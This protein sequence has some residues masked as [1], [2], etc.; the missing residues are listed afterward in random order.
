MSDR[1][2][3]LAIEQ[4]ILLRDSQVGVV[5]HPINYT[6]RKVTAALTDVCEALSVDVVRLLMTLLVE[7]GGNIL[8]VFILW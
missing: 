4:S 8:S 1:C 6:E 3:P 5:K 7:V 2:V